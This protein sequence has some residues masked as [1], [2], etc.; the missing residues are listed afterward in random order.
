MSTFFHDFFCL[1]VLRP[2]ALAPF[3]PLLLYTMP[4]VYT[5]LDARAGLNVTIVMSPFRPG[6]HFFSGNF[7]DQNQSWS[8]I[9]CGTVV[10]VIIPR[11]GAVIVMFFLFVFL[12]FSFFVLSRTER[13]FCV[14]VFFFLCA[15]RLEVKRVFLFLFFSRAHTHYDH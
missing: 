7:L 5:L 13:V 14:C 6:W 10:V 2:S 8:C 15:A 3:A 9:A 12:L 4:W 11:G 1:F